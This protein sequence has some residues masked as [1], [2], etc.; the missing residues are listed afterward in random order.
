MSHKK[1]HDQFESEIAVK[2]PNIILISQYSGSQ[3]KI[4]CKCKQCMSEWSTTPTH[5]LAG[6][7]CSKCAGNKKLT[8]KEYL[9]KLENKYPNHEIEA[10][11]TYDGAMK[12]MQFKCNICGHQWHTYPNNLL[13]CGCPSC[14]NAQKSSMMTKDHETFVEEVSELHDNIEIIGKYHKCNEKL[15]VRCTNCH[16]EWYVTP[17][18]LLSGNGCRNCSNDILHN[19]MINSNDDFLYKLSLLNSRITVISRYDGLKNKV[20]TKCNICGYIWDTSA[21]SLLNG[22]ACP[23]C[24]K[25]HLEKKV[26]LYFDNSKIDYEIEKS[27][28]DLRGI[29][30][31]K[32][33]YDL[34]VPSY[35][36]LIE[37]QGE[38]HYRPVEYFG[39]VDAFEKQKMHDELKRNYAISNQYNYIEIGFFDIDNI[40]TI[41]NDRLSEIGG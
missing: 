40:D 35:N 33:S 12:H 7:G 6:T 29:G 26:Q 13:K 28:N 2:N 27:F 32:L 17:L 18:S 8:H 16:R 4:R 23:K 30:G 11:S 20:T 5:L 24:K 34:F 38:Q 1:T 36:L 21:Q 10:L 37:L 25:S 14:T 41:L 19:K 9:Q 31:G 22:S 39:G 15:L 3:N